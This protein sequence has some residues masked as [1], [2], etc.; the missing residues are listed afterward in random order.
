MCVA[1]RGTLLSGGEG[2]RF[3]TSPVSTGQSRYEVTGW[4]RRWDIKRGPCRQ[5]HSL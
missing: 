1:Q 3:T 2:G 5:E 4:S